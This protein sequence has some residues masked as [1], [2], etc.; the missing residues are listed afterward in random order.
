MLIDHSSAVDIGIHAK[1]LS[2]PTA[3]FDSSRV[4]NCYKFFFRLFRP[5]ST[6]GRSFFSFSFRCQAE[7]YTRRAVHAKYIIIVFAGW[8]TALL[9]AA[10]VMMGRASLMGAVMRCVNKSFALKRHGRLGESTS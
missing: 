2:G 3:I 7:S 6:G 9:S 8:T 1:V 4:P 10:K 5:Y